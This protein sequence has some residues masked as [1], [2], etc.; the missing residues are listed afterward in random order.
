MIV[1]VAIV[2]L[3]DVDIVTKPDAVM[4]ELTVVRADSPEAVD[5]I[6]MPGTILFMEYVPTDNVNV[7][8]V[9]G[10][11]IGMLNLAIVPILDQSAYVYPEV[12]ATPVF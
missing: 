12:V 6:S 10:F 1:F 4:M 8:D 11:K 2:E 3:T 7:D 9:I 5:V